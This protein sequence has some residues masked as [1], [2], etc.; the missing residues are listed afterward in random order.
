MRGTHEWRLR[1]EQGNGIIPAHAGNTSIP[2]APARNRRDHPRA[3]GEHEC[4]AGDSG[5]IRGSSPRM[6][7][8]LL[9]SLHL[10]VSR[11]II[12]AHAGNTLGAAQ[13][14][15]PS[16]DHPRACGEHDELCRDTIKNTGSSPRMRG[17][18]AERPCCRLWFGI[19]PAHAGNTLLMPSRRYPAKDHPRA[20]GEHV[21]GA[22]SFISMLGS[23]PR[24]RGTR[25]S[26]V[27][28]W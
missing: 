11:G 23:S 2:S 7:G 9:L 26:P 21:D 14:H 15:H 4:D 22:A 12:P 28:S 20:C 17:T 6:R 24:M 10:S 13:G 5:G 8:T 27:R 18:H 25:P 19:I 16:R 3:C 1:N